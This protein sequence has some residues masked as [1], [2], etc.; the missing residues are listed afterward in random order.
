MLLCD[1]GR[2]QGFRRGSMSE[3]KN[4]FAAAITSTRRQMIAGFGIAFGGLAAGS[5]IWGKTQPQ[6]TKEGAGAAANQSR[7]SLHQEVA[8]TASPQR[9]YEVLL[10]SKQF[11]AVT[12]LPADI[13]PKAGGAFST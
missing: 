9:I 1:G 12:G 5:A 2:H 4:S 3:R 8:F 7:T 10:S 11:A 6:A 13:D